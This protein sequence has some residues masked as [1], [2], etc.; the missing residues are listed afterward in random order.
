L[1]HSGIDRFGIDRVARR[2]GVDPNL[3]RRH[4]HDRRVLLVDALLARTNAAMWSGDTGSLYTDLETVAA[5]ATDTSRTAMGRALFRRLLPGGDDVDLAE[6][7]SDVWSARFRDA[8]QILQRAADRGQLR[9]GIAP[10]EAIRMFAAA[11]Y[12]DVI[13]TDSPVRPEYAEQAVDIFLHGVLGAAGRD[14]P[15][16][17]AEHLFRHA[18]SDGLFAT[19]SAVEMARRAVVL[20]RA[21]A[22]ALP[23]PLVLLEAVRD[24]QGRVVDF[25]FREANRACCELTGVSRTELLGSNLLKALPTF[26][27]CGLLERYSDCLDAG[28]PLVLNDFEFR[29]FDRRRRYDI[30]AESAGTELI[31]ATWRDV[32]ARY[33]AAQIDQRYRKLMDFS[34]VPAALATPEGRLVTVNQALATMLGYDVDTLLTMTWQDL[35]A[36]ETV[37]EESEVVAD[38]LEGRRDS[39]RAVKEYLHANGHRVA[40]DLSLSC[41]RRPD[42]QVEHLIAQV[43]DITEFRKAQQR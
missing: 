3:I 8:A 9:D 11:F 15:W 38:I 24:D 26:A 7:S 42:G 2:A 35:T 37:P 16:A 36:P 28:G 20:N 30:R 13:F 21:W 34:A 5:L 31:T 23:D 18:D 40:A 43:V 39:Y 12:Y 10:E 14:R 29:D 17:E 1:V 19:D 32:T 6:I 33:Q 41:I 22:D 27:T 25:V 4:W